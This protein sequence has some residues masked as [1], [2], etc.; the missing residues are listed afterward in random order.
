MAWGSGA[1]ASPPV[2]ATARVEETADGTRV[3]LRPLGIGRWFGVLFLAVWLA[4]WAAGEA[5]AAWF[6]AGL[7]GAPLGLVEWKSAPLGAVALVMFAFL[8]VWLA[9]WTLGG[10]SAFFAMIRLACGADVFTLGADGWAFRQG[11]GR[12]GRSQRFGPGSVQRLAL[13]RRD[14]AL[15]AEADAKTIVLSTYGT[16]AD[17]R[18]LLDALRP[19]A[20]LAA[21]APDRS[22]GPQRRRSLEPAGPPAGYRVEPMPDGT[23]QVT[24]TAGRRLGQAGCLLFL[25]LFWNGIVG[26]FLLAG[27]GAIHVK[28]EGGGGAMTPGAWGYWLFLSP[29]ILVGLGLILGFLWSSFGREEW[30]VSRGL[31]EVHRA[32]PGRSWVRRYTDGTLLLDLTVDSDGDESWR[33]VLEGTGRKWSLDGGDLAKLRALGAMIA[34]QTGWP[35]REREP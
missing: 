16:E 19:I 12:W 3:T 11:I 9:L 2:G 5:F 15:I 8:L 1:L 33:L 20:G 6:L 22:I 30:R 32:I 7:V 17:R 4:G 18:W 28:I 21:D 27:L 14:R 35:L 25:V 26:V 10:I 31:L 24:M 34:E 23:T 13:R 29:F